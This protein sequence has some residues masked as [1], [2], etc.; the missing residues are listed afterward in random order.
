MIIGARVEHTNIDYTANHILDQ[1]NLVGEIAHKNNYTQVLPNLTLK[2]HSNDNWIYR[3]AFTTALARPDYYAIAPYI[4]VSSSDTEIFAGN[5]NLKA[6]YATNVDLMAEKYFSS[7]GLL[8]AGVFYKNLNDF[9]YTYRTSN[10]TQEDFNN[11]FPGQTNPINPTENWTFTQQRNGDNVNLYGVEIA[12]QRQLDFLPTEF[13]K[14]FGIYLN[15]TYTHSKAKG[16]SNEDGDF[17]ENMKLPGAAPHVFNGSISWEKDGFSARVSV[18]YTSDYIDELGS[19][20]FYDSYY[21]KQLFLDANMSYKVNSYLRIFAEANNLTNQPL[22]YYQ[23]SSQHLQQ[24][25][26]YQPKFNLGLK[27]D[28]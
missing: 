21:D 7:I 10:F 13:L 4:N 12:L 3:A 22:R 28:L 26:Y 27:I 1:D 18:N 24:M 8:S 6:T 14:A 11:S 19:D 17:R 2:Y 16:I 23:G 5:P 15:Y 9:I 25:E 20:A